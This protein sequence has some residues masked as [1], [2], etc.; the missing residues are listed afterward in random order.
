MFANSLCWSPGYHELSGEARVC[1]APVPSPGS[2]TGSAASMCCQLHEGE[3]SG[4][5]QED[6]EGGDLRILQQEPPAAHPV[7]VSEQ[8]QYRLPLDLY[9]S[10]CIWR[11]CQAWPSLQDAPALSPRSS[12]SRAQSGSPDRRMLWNQWSRE[13]LW[14]RKSRGP[15]TGEKFPSVQTSL[16]RASCMS[17]APPEGS[18]SMGTVSLSTPGVLGTLRG[19]GQVEGGRRIS[20]H[21]GDRRSGG[22]QG[23][24]QRKR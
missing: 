10:L 5:A 21:S 19:S 6:G 9:F 13:G 24:L 7:P 4:A 2:V 14:P 20:A 23:R 11:G 1:L 3:G 17:P 22:G 12:L 18:E 8:L 15:Q 16:S